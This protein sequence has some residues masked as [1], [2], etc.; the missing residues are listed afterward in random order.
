MNKIQL[1]FILLLATPLFAADNDVSVNSK[2]L[3]LTNYCFLKENNKIVF[4]YWRKQWA[5]IGNIK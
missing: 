1:S 3:K 5:I 2:T 4:L